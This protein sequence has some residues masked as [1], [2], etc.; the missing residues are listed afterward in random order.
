VLAAGKIHYVDGNAATIVDDG[1]GVIDVYDDINFLAVPGE[2]FVDG[3]VYDFVDEVMQTHLAG[4]T[5]V[6]CGTKADSFK[7]FE[8]FDVVASVAVVVAG[9]FAAG[10]YISRHKLPFAMGSVRLWV[11][12]DKS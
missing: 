5:D 7:A 6:H 3:I 8:D 1:D 2:S 11:A 4:G 12:E 9:G 10:R